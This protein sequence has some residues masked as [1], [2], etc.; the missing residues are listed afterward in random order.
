MLA[1]LANKGNGPPNDLEGQGMQQAARRDRKVVAAV[2]ALAQSTVLPEV[3]SGGVNVAW[4]LL[5]YSIDMP[6]LRKWWQKP[7]P[8]EVEYKRTVM[9]NVSGSV[10]A[11]QFLAVMGPEG[12]GKSLL[13]NMLAGRVKDRSRM[14]GVIRYNGRPF[15][16]TMRSGIG[17]VQQT[18]QLQENLT[19]KETLHY[20]ARLKLPQATEEID[21]IVRVEHVLDSLELTQCANT[22]VGKAGGALNNERRRLAIGLEMITNPPLLLLD[23]PTSGLDG[24]MALRIVRTL[25]AYAKAG[26]TV[27][28]SV[29]Q[30]SGRMF[31]L[32]DLFCMLAEGNPLYFGPAAEA[33]PY[34]NGLGHR[35]TYDCSPAEYLLD[36]A[37][38]EPSDASI[39]FGTTLNL[40][41]QWRQRQG[42]HPSGVVP[43]SAFPDAERRLSAAAPPDGG[44]VGK[45]E[46]GTAA[47]EPQSSWASAN[48]QRWNS[49]WAYQFLVLT[50]RNG[51]NYHLMHLKFLWLLAAIAI[52]ALLTGCLWYQRKNNTEGVRDKA[53]LVFFVQLF[54]GLIPMLSTIITFLQ[55][56]ALLRQEQE[57]GSYM[58]SAYF[59]SR[60]VLYLP[61]ELLPPIVFSCIVFWM[62]SL[63]DKFWRF[64]LFTLVL[65]MDC[66]VASSIG[67]AVGALVSTVETA[68]WI[69]AILQLL[70]LVVVDFLVLNAPAWVAWTK[71]LSFSTY[72]HR[73]LLRVVFPPEGLYSCQVLTSGV[74]GPVEVTQRCAFGEDQE[75]RHHLN[76][77][78]GGGA[79][80][81]VVLIAMLVLFRSSAFLFLRRSTLHSRV[82]HRTN[83]EPPRGHSDS[84]P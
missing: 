9:L 18:V 72:I 45:G 64:V 14:R 36:L 53:G 16:E 29:E 70:S 41:R 39:H 56:R 4:E 40:I 59:V 67:L 31:A 52:C 5:R 2:Q 63:N 23:E 48:Q 79:V 3:A 13:L 43:D 55:D 81:A 80:E 78:A 69:A 58:F 44:V 15:S 34:F 28:A 65:I 62:A 24:A 71:Y 25:S 19:V 50:Q 42:I 83:K 77:I 61:Y 7:H 8:D 47:G 27:I 76:A 35:P 30:P 11:G 75:L 73:L 17:F 60:N 22:R 49:S 21:S 10:H 54:W 74:N 66:M 38:A 6:K 82:P 46:G 12:S 26:R 84:N 57:A 1:A 51:K 32:F 68:I 33:M 37:V 20:A